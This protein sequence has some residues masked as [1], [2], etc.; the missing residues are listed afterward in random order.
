MVSITIPSTDAEIILHQ[1]A[2]IA[3]RYGSLGDYIT[4]KTVNIGDNMKAAMVADII[5]AM[6]WAQTK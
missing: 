4:R 2:D 3:A 5:K 1:Y 6:R